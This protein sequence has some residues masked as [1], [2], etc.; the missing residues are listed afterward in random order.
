MFVNDE[1]KHV[2]NANSTSSSGNDDNI[3]N[4]NLAGLVFMQNEI[5]IEFELQWKSLLKCSLGLS[6]LM[7]LDFLHPTKKHNSDCNQNQVYASV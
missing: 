6:E 1:T 7:E 5:S 2:D 3:M 4:W